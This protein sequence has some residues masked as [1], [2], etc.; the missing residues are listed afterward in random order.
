MDV[1]VGLHVGGHVVIGVAGGALLGPLGHRQDED[2]AEEVG[3]DGGRPRA[4][5]RLG[6]GQSV[7]AQAREPVLLVAPLGVLE[8]EEDGALLARAPLGEV[9]VG[10]RLHA[11]LGQVLAPAADLGT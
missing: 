4:Q 9:A 8:R 11:L 3:Q 7:L 1:L 5:G 10:A 2:R 6:G